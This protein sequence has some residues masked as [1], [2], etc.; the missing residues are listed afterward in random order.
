MKTQSKKPP[1]VKNSMR[2]LLIPKCVWLDQLTIDR[3]KDL[4]DGSASRGIRLALKLVKKQN[5]I[6][7]LQVETEGKLIGL[8]GKQIMM[9][10]TTIEIAKEIGGRDGS[11]VP[12]LSRGVRLAVLEATKLAF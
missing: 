8:R 7:Q 3:S 5:L 1:K 10:Q 2:E 6:C 9:D 4:A 11:E 12:N